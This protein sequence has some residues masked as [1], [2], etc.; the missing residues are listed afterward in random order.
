MGELIRRLRDRL[1]SL[2]DVRKGEGLGTL[3]AFSGLLLII[4]TA[5]TVLET[6]R[7]A[8][9]LVGP[10]PRALGLV[11]IA[12]AVCTLPAA[13]V[14]AR[15]SQRFGVR[16]SLRGSLLI[17]GGAAAA[18]FALPAGRATSIVVYV[19]SGVIASVVVPLF[20]MFVGAVLTVSQGRRLFGVI[21]AA[22]V[23]GGVAGSGLAAAAVTVLAPKALLLISG[24]L[25]AAASV[26][27]S[28]V[29]AS[30]RA[31]ARKDRSHG[32]AVA[33]PT[34]ERAF[35]LRV[36][37]IVFL[38]TMTL[39]SLDYLFKTAVARAVRPADIGRFVARF[40]LALNLLSLVVQLF[41]S[42]LVVQRLGVTTAVVLT[43]LLLLAGAAGALISGGAFA[44][45]A[46]LKIADGGL[47]YSLHRITGE[48]VYLPVA[49]RVRERAKPFIDGALGR[50]AQTLMGAALLAFGRST[51]SL[52]PLA[53]LVVVLVA[54][55]LVAAGTMRRPYL[56]LLR[57]ALSNGTADSESRIDPI[58]LESAEFLVGHLAS[59]DPLDV[60]A[61]MGALSR[62]G[63]SGIIPA[64]VLLHRDAGVLSRA[65]EI[66]GETSRTD[67]VPLA[68]EL[69][70]RS[71]EPLRL[72]AARSL[73]RVGE[74]DLGPL[75]SDPSPR[76]R[77]YAAVHLAL[78]DSPLDVRRHRS[79]AE[80]LASPP[81]SE[82]EL[83]LLAAIADASP[84]R[85]L[86]PLLHEL[87]ERRV[88]GAERTELL[89][90]GVASQRDLSMVP[91]LV[92]LHDTRAGREHARRALV[93]LGD[94]AFDAVST[95]LRDGSLPPG[96]RAH[97][98]KTLAR[99]G[100]QRA[101]DALLDALASETDGLVRY[102]VLRAL[103]SLTTARRLRVDR[104]RV[105]R[106]CLQ[107]LTTHYRLLAVRAV[108]EPERPA[109]E[110]WSGWRGAAEALRRGLLDDKLRQSLERAFRLLKVAHPREDIRRAYLVCVAGDPFARATAGEFLDAMLHR[111]DQQPLRALLRLAS[112]DLSSIERARR[113]AAW[114]GGAGRPPRSRDEALSALRDHR[115]PTVARL[116]L[117]CST[118]SRA[119]PSGR[120]PALPAREGS[121]A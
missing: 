119:V 11:Y 80:A 43:P 107:E 33:V 4:I 94:V 64:L 46:L 90:R 58:D 23:V 8:L 50:A 24:G 75:A 55:W 56:A 52:R 104:V 15:A 100:D 71:E 13:A 2:F 37:L 102:K 118:S 98:P 17:A 47:R 39:L 72:A 113:A 49:R 79:V 40:Y 53:T 31:A 69:L 26:A 106:M 59:K 36:G 95:A 19:A 21:A 1:S 62:R 29:R 41:V 81:G 30:E 28:R 67:W 65:L 117:L 18:L 88:A 25:F 10:G 68:R 14:S 34:V 91:A 20:W 87:G 63:R 74:L 73:A 83:G 99:F 54:L 16:T 38:S 45:V 42:R 7:D 48:L 60:I 76:L 12:I 82:P 89:A 110:P 103:E 111:R 27:V 3:L 115:D 78:R 51:G 85:A 35:L 86:W 108:L 101:A 5:H 57:R 70:C 32:A 61:A 44:M 93:G 109:A 77:A 116:A 105:E 66:F 9:L 6:A 96:L 121:N 97:L 92:L 120:P 114:I 84:N 112:D 22:G